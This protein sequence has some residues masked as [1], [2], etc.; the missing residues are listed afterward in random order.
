MFS[1]YPKWTESVFGHVGGSGAQI[2][3]LRRLEI[4][5]RPINGKW[6]WIASFFFGLIGNSIFFEKAIV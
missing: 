5:R 1:G 2:N 3:I 4:L 6:V